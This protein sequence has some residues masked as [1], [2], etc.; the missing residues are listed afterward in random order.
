MSNVVIDSAGER[1]VITG[2]VMH[3]PC[4]IAHPEWSSDLDVDK[5]LARRSRLAF[6]G[7][8]ADTSSLVFGT[9]FAGPTGGIV[10]AGPE[11][12]RFIPHAS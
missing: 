9:H 2:D 12:Y 7:E 6:L 5:D 10:V 4:Q 1:A 3:H 8:F 11:T